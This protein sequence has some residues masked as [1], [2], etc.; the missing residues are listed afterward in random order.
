V[1]YGDFHSAYFN[2]AQYVPC[3]VHV[4]GSPPPAPV[5]ACQASP[6]AA[7]GAASLPSDLRVL[8]IINFMRHQ[9]GDMTA[10]GPQHPSGRTLT[11]SRA[12]KP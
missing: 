11:V 5:F 12:A 7:Y 1:D 8:D 10:K 9:V 2:G 3:I 4:C 6:E